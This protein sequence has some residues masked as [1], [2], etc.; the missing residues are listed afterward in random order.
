M[1][2]AKRHWLRLIAAYVVLVGVLAGPTMAFYFSVSDAHKP[3][4]IRFPVALIVA[5]AFIHIHGN[6]RRALDRAPPSDFE[7]ALQPNPATPKVD[8]FFL[9]LREGLK[10]SIVS[11]GYF[12][13][14]MWPRLLALA[15]RRGSTQ[16]LER[17]SRSWLPRRGP[18]LRVIDS[19]ITHLE[20]RS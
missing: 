18:S 4:V 19:L 10:N 15:D 2:P 6:I 11:W 8:P 12:E 1:S 5:I 17:P 13:H 20:R 14:V 16:P 3:L 7:Q 9:K